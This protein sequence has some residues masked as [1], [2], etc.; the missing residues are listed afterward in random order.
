MHAGKRDDR[1]LKGD[2]QVVENWLRGMSL[3][4]QI[5]QMSQIDIAML[6][7]DGNN[8]GKRLNIDQ[9]KHFIGELGVGSVLNTVPVPWSAGDYR[10]AAVQ[11]QEIAKEYKRPPVIWGL[12]SVH[13]ANYVYGANWTPQP[14]NLAASFNTTT[15][16][17]A[18]A[19]A[20][21]D[22]RA[23]G[24]SWL[25]SPL[26]GIALQPYWS[27]VYET[28]GEDPLVVGR[29]AAAMIEGIQ[30]ADP[31]PEAI[32]SRAAACGKHFVGYSHP[33][34]GHDRAPSWIPR[35]HLYQ[36]FVPPWQEAMDANVLTVME[37]YT[38]V[39]GVPNVAN[40]ETTRYLL[41]QR[42]GFEGVLVTDYQEI[43][44]LHAWHKTV[45]DEE[46]AVIRALA[47]GTVDMS[48]IPWDA[49]GFRGGVLKA[50][51]N[52]LVSSQRI[53]ESARRVL[54][55]KQQLN[56]FDE[57]LSEKDP[58]LHLVGKDDEMTLEMARQ[59]IILAK[60]DGNVLPWNAKMGKKV[61]VTGPAAASVI[62][63]TGGWSG[64]WQGAPNEDD[65]FTNGSSVLK[66]LSANAGDWDISYSCGTN[67]LGGECDDAASEKDIVDEVEGW[68]GLGPHNSVDRAVQ[69]ASDANLVIVCV[70]EEAYTE[71]PG[72]IRSLRLPDGQY[73]LVRAL[74][75]GTAAKIV[76]VYFGGRPRLLGSMV[77]ES[78]SV[79]V[80]F[81]PGPSGG[82]A[83]SDIILGTVNPSGRMPM[84]YPAFDDT[85]G[86]PYFHAVSDQCTSGSGVMPYYDY[87]A[88]EVQW[89]FGHGLSYT[90]FE[91][92]GLKVTGDAGSDVQVSFDVKNTGEMAGAEVVLGFM[93][94][95]Y[96]STT[97][98]Y[99]RLKYFEKVFLTSKETK[100]LSFTLSQ[101]DLTFV[102][103]HDDSHYINDPSK[104][105]WIGI[106]ASTD[107]RSTPDDPMCVKVE[108]NIA[109]SLVEPSCTA[110]C[111]LWFL[112]SGCAKTV[113]L[114]YPGCIDRCT[115]AGKHAVTYA[116]VGSKGWGWNYVYCL[117]SVLWGMQQ[118]DD[119]KCEE[120]TL[121]CRDIF[122][123]DGL[124][125]FGSG[126][127]TGALGQTQA[128]PPGFFVAL[129]AGIISS[130]I[131]FF[132][133]RGKC[134]S[135]VEKESAI[136]FTTV[137]TMEEDNL[138]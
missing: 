106:G 56:M 113:G 22:T 108:G 135:R 103:A 82:E 61:V 130:F 93:F 92:S 78:D 30:A 1:V 94:D 79:L 8:G 69:A 99:K 66:A 133:L 91:Y 110:A 60:N 12:D 33:H 4:E 7:E 70:G 68:M 14:I 134:Q 34:N 76:L 87:T 50:V 126:K 42:L 37:S 65:W 129:L 112:D 100:S 114:S 97:P 121:L 31:N 46:S 24:I 62:Y 123:T 10:Q 80:G 115:K 75:S 23:A 17:Q 90:S 101:D 63:Q 119:V 71:K 25:F 45:A 18:G 102:G 15:A 35:R 89:P 85:A 47:E 39:D 41:R 127:F 86:S 32:P 51:Q 84:T 107:C 72:D 19:L 132:T 26:L 77:E 16:R 136:Q 55:L 125:E 95:E 109:V 3:E 43:L 73:E 59:S 98:E 105:F 13:G 53:E 36:Y 83:V 116:G 9:V 138:S 20:S 124:N 58:N 137:N 27:R 74:K 64:Q 52:D 38:E 81:L 40:S 111:D 49:D 2:E 104:P 67:I 128:I 21:R 54:A 29:F 11:I 120:M 117:E 88:C 5:G 57:E 131:I 118:S 96:R 122:R 6:L 28:F 48:M 44:N